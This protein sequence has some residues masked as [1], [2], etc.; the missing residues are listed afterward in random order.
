[1]VV[2]AKPLQDSSTAICKALER[3]RVSPSPLMKALKT[4]AFHWALGPLGH[5]G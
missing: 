4:K 1:M 2:R 3:H 5:K